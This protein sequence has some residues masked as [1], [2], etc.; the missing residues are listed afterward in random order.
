VSSRG[1]GKTAGEREKDRQTGEEREERER[2][3][4]PRE[5]E[6]GDVNK[7]VIQR[8]G[9]EAEAESNMDPERKRVVR[10]TTCRTK[11]STC[12]IASHSPLTE[13]HIL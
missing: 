3:K 10:Q 13:A 4:K 12:R 5:V 6:E 8:T 2:E 9:R 11:A 7:K 1:R